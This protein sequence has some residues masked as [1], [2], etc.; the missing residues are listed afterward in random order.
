MPGRIIEELLSSVKNEIPKI[1]EIHVKRVVIELR[2]TA[3]ELNTGHVCVCYTLG[4]EIT[5]NCCQIQKLAGSLAG[6]PAMKIAELSR[7]WDLSETVVGIAALN[8]LSQLAIERNRERYVITDGNFIDHIEI[9]RGDTVALVGNIHPFVPKIKEKT[10]K[11]FI[12][13]RNPRL[14]GAERPPRHGR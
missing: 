13:E 5:P 2:Y 12:L 10:E 7:S 8:T 11:L 3:V 1:D 9:R 14:R 6:S 4:R